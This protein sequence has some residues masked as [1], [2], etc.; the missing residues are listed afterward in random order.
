[1]YVKYVTEEA[2]TESPKE[3]DTV[4]KLFSIDLESSYCTWSIADVRKT[5]NKQEK[6]DHSARNKENGDCKRLLIPCV[7]FDCILIVDICHGMS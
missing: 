3:S 6:E 2:A 5:E 7:L 1:M 4:F